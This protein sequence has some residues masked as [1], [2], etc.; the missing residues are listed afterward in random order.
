MTAKSW[1]SLADFVRKKREARRLTQSELAGLAKISLRALANIEGG[2][3]S[4][5]SASTLIGLADALKVSTDALLG[6]KARRAKYCCETTG[7]YA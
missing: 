6:R 7:H 3:V 5:P 2:Q 4:D 1:K